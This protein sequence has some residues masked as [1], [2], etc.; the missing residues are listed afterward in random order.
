MNKYRI[1]Y[2]TKT[3]GL[4]PQFFYASATSEDNARE[5]MKNFWGKRFASSLVVILKVELV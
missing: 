3:C 5:A 2:L 4:R 1:T